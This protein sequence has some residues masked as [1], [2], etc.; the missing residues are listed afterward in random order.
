MKDSSASGQIPADLKWLKAL[1][2][3][4]TVT[5]IA[6]FIVIVALFVV[7][8]RDIGTSD[9]PF[10]LP[11]TIELPNGEKIRAF[12]RGTDWFAIVTDDDAILISIAKVAT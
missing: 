2:I 12:T 6:G 11:S 3:T 4:L 5:M 1:V 8:F 9:V 10:D 7:R